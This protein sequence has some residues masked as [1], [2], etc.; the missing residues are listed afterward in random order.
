KT[1]RTFASNSTVGANALYA[2]T[3]TAPPFNDGDLWVEVGA[4]PANG[5]I[6]HETIG[7]GPYPA[8][9][10]LLSTA[11]NHGQ[12]VLYCSQDGVGSLCQRSDDLGQSY[13]PGVSAMG[14]GFGPCGG[15]H[16]HAKIAPDGTAF[17]PDRSC[18]GEQGGAFS[19]N[20][21]INWSQTT[22][23]GSSSAGDTNSDPSI[24]FD[25][26]STAYFCYAN[27][28]G[29]GE[30]HAHVA[31][32]KRT[33]STIE[34]IRDSDLGITHGIANVVFPEAVAGS[35][36]RAACGFLGTNTAGDFQS[37]NFLGDWYL[38]I[39]TT[40]DEG[41]NWVTVNATPNTPV[42]NRAGVC[43]KGINC[44]SGTAPRNLLDFNEVTMDDKGRVLFG[45]SHGSSANMRVARQIGGKT[46][47]AASDV[48]EPVVPK[49]PCLSG[50][51]SSN[52]VH[53]TWK[54]PDNGGA[55]ITGYKIFRGNSAGNEVLLGVTGA[56]NSFD[57]I[58]ADPSQPVY[59]KVSAVNV[60]D[61]AGGALSDEINFA[62]TPGIYLTSAASRISHSGV[63]FDI[64]LPLYGIGIECRSGGSAGNYT[65]VLNFGNP[66]ANYDAITLTSG[67]GAISNRAIIGGA[68]VVNLSGVTNAQRIAVTF[69]NVRDS[70]GNAASFTLNAG[71]LI[72]DTT[73]DG[74]A[75][76]ADIAQ[77]KSKSGQSVDSANFRADVTTDGNLNSADIALVKSKSGTALP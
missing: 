55:D 68:L 51:R 57:D 56:T 15:I 72:G 6:D 71:I 17:L 31:V 66:V 4:A 64:N 11:I 19:L 70:V 21:G 9:L 14:N 18:G 62:A 38:F 29:S 41:Q 46:L 22:A 75:N 1:G 16:G 49:A 26:N 58:T 61:L 53:L 28:E 65:L 7:S 5:G 27:N 40:Y 77:T 52:G 63:S 35:A 45:Y 34:W 25:E 44:G 24:A 33:G 42:Q 20:A 69:T 13:G 76:S 59:Y 36:G 23:P 60:V 73:G 10:S 74:N 67:T 50:T 39:A 54:I 8:S 2:Y 12:Y 37:S 43:L 30:I 32:G 48:A 47:L 3:D